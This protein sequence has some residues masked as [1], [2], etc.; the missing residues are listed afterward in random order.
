M[1]SSACCRGVV[2]G[3]IFNFVN[4]AIAAIAAV[5]FSF[6]SEHWVYSSRDVR[7]VLFYRY[8]FFLASKT[9]AYSSSHDDVLSVATGTRFLGRSA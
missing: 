8:C 5:N 4:V 2:S 3:P 7:V 1:G 9:M 6:A